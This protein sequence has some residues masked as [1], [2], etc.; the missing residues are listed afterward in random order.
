MAEVEGG[1]L[2]ASSEEAPRVIQGGS[3]V[4][5]SEQGA[6]ETQPYNPQR[7]R[8]E[9]ARR[10]AFWFVWLLGASVAIHYTA[11]VLIHLFSKGDK[12]DSKEV[13]ERLNTIFNAWLPVISSLVSAAAAY[14]FVKDKEEQPPGGR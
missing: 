10:M 4:G 13:V 5:A 9:T 2:G 6:V 7:Y 1:S 11:V 3:I 12:A 8:A 14:Y